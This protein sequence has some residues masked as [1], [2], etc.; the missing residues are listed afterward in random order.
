MIEEEPILTVD[1]LPDDPLKMPP[2]YWRSGGA[3]FHIQD[4]LEELVVLLQKFNTPP[5]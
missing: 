2:P 3:I 5:R 4:A 1:Q